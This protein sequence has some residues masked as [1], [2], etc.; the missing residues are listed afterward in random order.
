ML[1]PQKK[2]LSVGSEEG[3][4][5]LGQDGL[6][7]APLPAPGSPSALTTGKVQGA[8]RS[9]ASATPSTFQPLHG[10]RKKGTLSSIFFSFLLFLNW[11]FQNRAW[12]CLAGSSASCPHPAAGFLTLAAA[13][14]PK[15]WPSAA[16]RAWSSPGRVPPAPSCSRAAGG[17]PLAAAWQ[18]GPQR[19][20]R[21][22]Q[23]LVLFL[24][25]L[26][27]LTSRRRSDVTFF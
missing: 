11:I 23:R 3:L 9:S 25:F 8:N 21:N 18:A 24:F 22:Q 12:E 20:G 10:I 14:R 26:F 5:S 15:P 4:K 16:P 2:K 1:P 6:C 7:L 19:R 13:A 27:Y 17:L